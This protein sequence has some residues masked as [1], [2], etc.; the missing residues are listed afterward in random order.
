MVNKSIALCT[1]LG[2]KT[3]E[4]AINSHAQHWKRN[5]RRRQAAPHA[6]REETRR[7]LR[8]MSRVDKVV[9]GEG[10]LKEEEATSTPSSAADNPR[11]T[12]PA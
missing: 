7:R 3:Q 11:K 8:A 1:Y 6:P 4:N 10:L 2:E 12:L 5:T 9:T